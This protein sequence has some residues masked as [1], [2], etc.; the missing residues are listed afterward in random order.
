MWKLL[1]WGTES[2][3]EAQNL[4][5]VQNM[6]C[7][8]NIG[9]MSNEMPEQSGFGPAPSPIDWQIH[10]VRYRYV[11]SSSVLQG[12]GENLEITRELSSVLSDSPVLS[13]CKGLNEVSCELV[14]E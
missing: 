2:G 4:I 1:L 6:E 5:A 8:R 9:N 14:N 3:L 7:F 11:L 13:W 12:M 10:Q